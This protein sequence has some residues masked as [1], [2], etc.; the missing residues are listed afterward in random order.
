MPDVQAALLRALDD[1]EPGLRDLAES[2]ADPGELDRPGLDDAAAD[3]FLRAFTALLRE[4][5]R[6]ERGQ[7]S[8]VMETAIPALVE[9][10][11]TSLDM[12]RGHV[13][14]FT[15]LAPRLVAGVPEDQRADAAVWLARYA[16]DYTAEVVERATA[17]ER[18]RAGG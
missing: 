11:Q 15:L 1:A 17:V 7:R 4:G 3:Q 16:S 2:A 12:L 10:G 5:L 8:M 14:F 6:G 18:E 9:H 13:R